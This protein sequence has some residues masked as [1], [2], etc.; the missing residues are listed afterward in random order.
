MIGMGWRL[1]VPAQAGGDNRPYGCLGGS[2]P[3]GP[4]PKGYIPLG[5]LVLGHGYYVCTN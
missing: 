4:P 3:W 1:H 2:A 5:T